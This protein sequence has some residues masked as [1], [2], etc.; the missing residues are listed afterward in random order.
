MVRLPA[1]NLDRLVRSTGQILTE[2]LR[3]ASVTGELD[4]LDGQIAEMAAECVRFRKASAAPL[5]R[6][7]SQPEY[8]SV[9]RHIGFVEQKVRSLAAQSRTARLLQQRSA[10]NTRRSAEQLQRDVWSARMAPAED[11]FE[12]FRKMVR[13]LARE[14]NKEIDFRLSGSGVRADR[15]VLQALKD[16]VMHLLRNAI[17]HGI[18][19]PR[20]ARQQGKI[21]GGFPDPASGLPT[22]TPDRGSGRRW[23]RSR[24]EEGG[25]GA[26]RR[27]S[28]G[29]TPPKSWR[30]PSFGRVFPLPPP[31]T[32]CPGGAWDSR[33]FTK[34]CIASRET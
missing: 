34:P 18:E 22:R 20:G 10:W 16:P 12:G 29:R 6:L 5:W 21:A 13:D 23:P 4:A 19:T 1:E 11:L 9:I 14:E 28:P 33:W 31:S 26:F 2:S 3:Q 27:P 17:S 7:A 15:I 30:E 8:S 32:V 24:P 25:Q